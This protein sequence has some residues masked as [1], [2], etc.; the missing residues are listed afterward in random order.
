MMK[1]TLQILIILISVS[2]FANYTY[3]N[4]LGPTL[5]PIAR[6]IQDSEGEDQIDGIELS[7]WRNI[8]EAISAIVSGK[9]K[10]S[11]LPITIGA[12][13]AAEGVEIKLAAV[14]MWNGFFFVSKEAAIN[15]I[16][17]LRGK[18]VYTLH[19]PGQTADIILKG[20]IEKAGY[21]KEIKVVYVS[22]PE[23]VQLLAADKAEVLL[24]PE[25]FVSLAIT[26]VPTA[27][28]GMS[29]NELWE[30]FTG[31]KIDVPTSG[32]FVDKSVDKD[33]VETFLL[34][35]RQ[36][37]E[38]SLKD[39]QTTTEVVSQKMGG[40][41]APVLKNAIQNIDFVYMDADRVEAQIKYYLE[42]LKTVDEKLVG[43]VDYEDFF[44]NQK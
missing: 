13:M 19:A 4:P 37:L 18:I 9:A 33:F 34:L 17:D 14:S 10:L 30:E 31:T 1:K 28:R 8:D 32:L 43:N 24:I 21:E 44:Y 40:F 26:K 41:P 36:S 3:I 15:N 7:Y 42:T 23:S 22:G 20:A 2:L 27:E 6:L 35:Y 12:K 5:V 38:L 39:L 16:D 25:P 29:I 11:L